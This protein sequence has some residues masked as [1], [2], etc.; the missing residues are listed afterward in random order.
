MNADT[1]AL[2]ELLWVV[3]GGAERDDEEDEDE[4]QALSAK[5]GTARTARN[6]PRLTTIQH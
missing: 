2:D 4:P 1:D 5:A 6:R 3:L